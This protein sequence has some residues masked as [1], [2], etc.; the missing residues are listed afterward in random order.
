M[1]EL[2]K[3][4]IAALIILG[5][6]FLVGLYLLHRAVNEGN[7]WM[8]LVAVIMILVGGGKILGVLAAR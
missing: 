1:E 8:G 4:I 2:A 3:W 7:F 5:I 6:I